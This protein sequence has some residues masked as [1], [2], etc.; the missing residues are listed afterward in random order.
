MA[1]KTAFSVDLYQ[2]F[3]ITL[4]HY[5][6]VLPPLFTHNPMKKL[7]L[8]DIDGTLI[9]V[10]KTASRQMLRRVVEEVF[11]IVLPPEF[12]FQLGGKTDYQIMTEIA[13]TLTL[14]TKWVEERRSLIYNKLVEHTTPLSNPAQMRVLAGVEELIATLQR[15]ADVT[16]GLLTGNIQPTAYL[17]LAPHGLTP[18]FGFGAFGDDHIERTMLPPIALARANAHVGKSA[19]S[20]EN[21]V[22]IGDTLNDIRCAKAHNIKVVAVASGH[23]S[24]EALRHAKADVV[25]EDF[26]DIQAIVEL[27]IV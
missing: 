25:V 17:K 2:I 11:E 14:P 3:A 10:E 9:S 16:L 1:W 27:L 23:D 12:V 4:Y 6:G 20:P 15:R 19:F 8:F 22:I 26:A 7:L 5:H 18:A 21:T 13:Q 24:A